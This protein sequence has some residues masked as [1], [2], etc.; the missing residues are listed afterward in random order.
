MFTF[1]FPVWILVLVSPGNTTPVA[2]YESQAAC[3]E[4]TVQITKSPPSIN[5]GHLCV[6]AESE[7]HVIT[8]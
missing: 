7:D 2:Y 6:P 1:T 8:R 4:A 3:H 5:I